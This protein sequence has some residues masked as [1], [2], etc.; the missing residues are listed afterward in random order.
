MVKLYN[1]YSIG[2]KMTSDTLDSMKRIYGL[3]DESDSVVPFEQ[4]EHVIEETEITKRNID[5]FARLSGDNNKLHIDSIYAKSEGPFED[6]IA[7]GVLVMGTVSSALANFEGDIII[8]DF[9]E[10]DFVNPVYIGDNIKADCYISEKDGRNA[11]VEI[12]VINTETEDEVITGEV[13]I[14]NA[15]G[16]NI[17]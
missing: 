8:D 1:P 15:E 2:L 5:E 11:L 6:I 7:H 3:E 4:G 17:S 10:L 12:K 9:S 16:L 14:L 13:N